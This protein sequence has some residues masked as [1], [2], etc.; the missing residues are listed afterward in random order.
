MT[1]VLFI[2]YFKMEFFQELREMCN[3]NISLALHVYLRQAA[4]VH[5]TQNNLKFNHRYK[6]F[7]STVFLLFCFYYLNRKLKHAS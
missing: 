5:L 6:A 7:N 3:E 4:S 2:Y 1:V